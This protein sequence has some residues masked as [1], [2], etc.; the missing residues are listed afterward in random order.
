[1]DTNAHTTT[2]TFDTV[3]RGQNARTRTHECAS[4]E[5]MEGM[6]RGVWGGHVKVTTVGEGLWR[7]VTN[8]TDN[9]VIKH[10]CITTIYY[11][12]IIIYFFAHRYIHELP[13]VDGPLRSSDYKGV[14][15]ST[16]FQRRATNYLLL[17]SETAQTPAFWLGN[18]TNEIISDDTIAVDQHRF[19]RQQCNW[20][21]DR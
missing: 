4:V 16:G 10:A 2:T 21:I 18:P 1:M 12:T 20:I 14:F 11:F 19:A 15:T 6:L 7:K 5:Q 8:E 17:L 3:V 13:S 9:N